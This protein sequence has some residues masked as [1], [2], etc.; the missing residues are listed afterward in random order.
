MAALTC[1]LQD[2]LTF[3]V[4]NRM[5]HVMNVGPDNRSTMAIA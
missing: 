1:L 5:F 2:K 3:R 4:I